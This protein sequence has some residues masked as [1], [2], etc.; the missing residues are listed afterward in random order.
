MEVLRSKKVKHLSADAVKSFSEIF[1]LEKYDGEYA[2]PD[3]H[4]EWWEMCTSLYPRV[5]IAAPRDCAKST[6]IT[7]AYVLCQMLFRY[8]KYAFI[9]GNTE[10]DGIDFLGE[11]TDELRGNEK[12]RE[13][14]KVSKFIK[15]GAKNLVV[16]FKDGEQFRIRARGAGQ[17]IR[18]KKWQKKRPDLIVIDDLEDDEGVM[19]DDRREKLQKWFTNA[20]IP[21]MSQENGVIRVVGT[22]L[23]HDSLLM[24][25]INSKSSW[26]SRLY[27]AHTSFDDFR[28]LIWAER[29][30][31]EKLR[32]RRQTFIDAGDPEGYSKEYLNDPTDLLDP[33]F[34][35]DDFIPMNELDAQKPMSYYVGV[36]WALSEN[37][38]SDFTAIVVGGYDADGMLNIVDVRKI[39]TEDISVI[40]DAL[41]SVLVRYSPDYYLIESGVYANAIM[42]MFNHEMRKR[43]MFTNVETYTPVGDKKLRARSIQQRMRSGGVRFDTEAEWFEGFKNELRKFPKATHDDQVDALAWL[44]RGID[45]FV[46]APTAE[47]QEAADFYN[48]KEYYIED[49]DDFDYS[50]TGY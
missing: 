38:R 48:E 47:E 27:K 33:Y 36:D 28:E 10:D 43:N 39:R 11:I 22:I 26:K 13:W 31:E 7:F 20:V 18:G 17:P 35:E 34:S 21:S 4:V 50:V 2:V 9:I 29:W 3:I 14:F 5:A 1:L 6:A 30:T 24:G 32:A 25:L 8:S 15:E 45:E 16:E 40:V 12:L 44:G 41:F 19:S 42:P 23:H 37:N 46:E 49:Q